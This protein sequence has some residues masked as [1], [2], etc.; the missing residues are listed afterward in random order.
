MALLQVRGWLADYGVDLQVYDYWSW[1]YYPEWIVWWQGYQQQQQQ[2]QQPEAGQP[3][4]SSGTSLTSVIACF[5]FCLLLSA[6]LCYCLKCAAT[7][8]AGTVTT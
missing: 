5:C 3:E 8:T 1:R 7:S 6:L 2:G 4:V